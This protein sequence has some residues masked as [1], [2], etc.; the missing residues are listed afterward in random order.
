MIASFVC[1]SIFGVVPARRSS[2]MGA[3]MTAYAA[4]LRAIGLLGTI[5]LAGCSTTVTTPAASSTSSANVPSVAPSSEPPAS[6][7]V[8]SPESTPGGSPGGF[9]FAADD[10]VAYYASIGYA[11]TD[12]QPSTKAVGY[13]FRTCSLIDAAG[14]THVVGVVVDPA[15]ALANGFASV[16]GTATEAI[17]SPSDA[18]DPLAAFLGAMLGKDAGAALLPWL[19]GHLGDTYEETTCGDLKVATY[20]ASPT[21]HSTLYLELANQAYLEAPKPS[22]L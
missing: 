20:T 5:L 12:P 1:V 2:Q 19:A 15:G 16:Q 6:A 3:F 8:P 14:R 10:V 9:A 13:T 4:K 18:L 17:L 21:D 7:P 11:C 22:G